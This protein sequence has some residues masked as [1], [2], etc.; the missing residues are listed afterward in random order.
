VRFNIPAAL[1]IDK[2][3]VIKNESG[4]ERISDATLKRS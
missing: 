3:M 2:F 1:P 4:T